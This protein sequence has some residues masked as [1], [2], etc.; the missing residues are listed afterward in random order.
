MLL[1]PIHSDLFFFLQFQVKKFRSENNALSL[2]SG[3]PE[4]LSCSPLTLIPSLHI[5]PLNT[6]LHLADTPKLPVDFSW[7]TGFIPLN[8]AGWGVTLWLD[9]TITHLSL[10][11]LR[12][13][14]C[15]YFLREF[16]VF[17]RKVTFHD[18]KRE[19]IMNTL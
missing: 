9:T 8:K 16:R 18:L 12:S 3:V 19:H 4:P 1:R 2:S 5:Q 10:W 6:T 14:S 7:E 17:K 13:C 15:P 11:T